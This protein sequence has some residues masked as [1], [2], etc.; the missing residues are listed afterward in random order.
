MGG[1]PQLFLPVQ[2][3]DFD[4]NAISAVRLIVNFLHPLVAVVNDLADAVT[5]SA[6]GVDLKARPFQ[7]L[8]NFPLRLKLYALIVAD[9]VA[10]N[11]KPSPCR[12]GRVKLA[13][14]ASGSVAGVGEGAFTFSLLL[15]IERFKV[16]LCHEHF[17]SHFHDRG[18]GRPPATAKGWT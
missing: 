5:E 17:A 9:T 13:D 1:R 10:E 14:G 15:L 4:D 11:V 6:V 2:A 18:V 8:Q 7:P 3:I 16:R 12:N